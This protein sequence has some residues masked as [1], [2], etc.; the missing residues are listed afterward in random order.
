MPAFVNASNVRAYAGIDGISA[1][2]TEANLGSN[3]RAA[4]AFLQK[5][6]GRQFELQLAT[7][8]TFTT[9]GE[10]YISIP[11][12]QTA[13]SVSLNSSAQTS[14]TDYHLIPD[15]HQTGVSIGIQF[16]GFGRGT[17]YR[18]RADWFDRNLDR[19]P[20]LVG[21]EPND[22]TI[23]GDWGHDPLPDELLHATKV[24]AAWYTRRPDSLLGGVSLTAAGSEIDM[25]AIPAEVRQFIDDWKLS[26]QVASAG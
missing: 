9:N 16:R 13:S 22:L 3:I 11:D 20:Y 12:L 6:T 24:L 2:W 26:A 8:K 5:R 17:D 21:S 14:G 10:A 18:S 19:Y 7:T 25:S 1:P 15:H 4:S 23:T